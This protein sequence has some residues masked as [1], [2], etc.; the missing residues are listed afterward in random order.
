VSIGG[1]GGEKKLVEARAHAKKYL[2]GNGDF[3]LL[4]RAAGLL[5]YKPWDEV[6]PYAVCLLVICGF[7]IA[8]CVTVALFAV[9]M[10]ASGDSLSLDPS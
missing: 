1:G 9:E 10:V 5:A 8:N 4:R 2:S 6:E 7:G 3:E